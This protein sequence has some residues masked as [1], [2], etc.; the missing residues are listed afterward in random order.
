[1]RPFVPL[2]ASLLFAALPARAAVFTVGGDAACTHGSLL[3][4][5]SAAAINGPALDEIRLANNI[6]YDSIIAPI[7]SHSVTVRGGYTTCA[8]AT[9]TGRTVI[10][11]TTAGTSGTFATSGATG[12]H[13]LVLENLELREG[14]NN[15]RRGGALRIEG[16]FGVTL[17]NVT[18]TENLAGRGGGIYL[19]GTNEAQL[20]MDGFTLVSSNVARV[21]GGGIYCINGG[22]VRMRGAIIANTAEDGGSDPLESGNGGGMALYDCRSEQ[23]GAG[24]FIGVFAN[25]AARNGGGYYLRG[26]SELVVDG[27]SGAPGYVTDNTA[28]EIG[29]GIAID[30]TLAPR[31]SEVDL[32]NSYVERTIALRGGG[33]GLVSGGIVRSTRTAAAGACHNETYCSTLSDNAPPTGEIGL[34]CGAY[35]GPGGE[36]RLRGTRVEGNCPA[37]SGWTFR[38]KGSARLLLDSAIVADNG[39]ANPFFFESNFTGLLEIAWSTVTRNFASLHTGMFT[40]PSDGTSSGTLR[41]YGTILGE[42]FQQF[43]VVGGF[44][45]PPPMTFTYDCLV[46]DSNFASSVN[47]TRSV[48]MA[49]PYGMVAPATGNYRLASGT[50]LPVDWCDASLGARAGGDAGGNPAIYDAPRF[51]QFGERDIG[52]YELVV[53]AAPPLFANGF[54]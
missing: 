19:D 37:G 53:A 40:V 14:G 9:A 50:S 34:G 3:A 27:N 30:D 36:L 45:G 42:P 48:S 52:A 29:G 33:I 6:A 46:V 26:G 25:T 11:G 32:D 49:P 10:R 23:A 54:E 22:I 12:F 38:I 31:T 24:G 20:D 44:G 4:A 47:P 2:L 21:G 1:M 8:A 17:R 51:N 35:V 15:T 39:G 16:A 13:Q 28:G 5:I 41:V 43:V 18:I 7:A